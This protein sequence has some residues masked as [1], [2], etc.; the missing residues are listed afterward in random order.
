VARCQQSASIKQQLAAMALCVVQ[1]SISPIAAA[2]TD[3]K[4]KILDWQYVV[5]AET[6]SQ[7][8][9]VD[10]ALTTAYPTVGAVLHRQPDSVRSIITCTGTLIGCD[11][12]LTAAHCVASDGD[13]THYQVFLQHG[14]LF[15]VDSIDW[16]K[17]AYRPPNVASGSKSDIAVLRLAKSVDGIAPQAVNDDREQAT[18]SASDIVGFGRTAANNVNTGLKRF[19]RVVA[20]PCPNAF[21]QS[22]L[23][24]WR[25]APGQGGSDTCY[26]DSG[27]PLILSENRDPSHAVVSGVTSGGIDLACASL[28]RAY[29]TSVF[30]NSA[31]IKEAANLHVPQAQCGSSPPLELTD[32]RY[33]Q[34][35]GQINPSFPQHVFAVT[36]EKVTRL[37]IGANI[38]KPI[39][40]ADENFVQQPQL[41]VL[42]GSGNRDT[43]TSVGQCE[44]SAQ[45]T[46]CEIPSPPDDTYTIILSG[47]LSGDGSA[48]QAD[49]QLVVSA[50]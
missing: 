36:V 41:Y 28:D 43:K 10:G 16:P 37:R 47:D 50:Y 19:G 25:Y 44:A 40:T 13:K 14:G 21:S 24:C 45:A 6:A 31:W 7:V 11:A 46:F 12:F 39:G 15:D 29:D 26:G 18:G 23:I 27:G 49:F 9:I 4:P 2:A 22:D 48:R 1:A 38:A 3:G 33:R 30:K 8:R 17:T 42:A 5:G 32:D 20:S 35:T 34:F